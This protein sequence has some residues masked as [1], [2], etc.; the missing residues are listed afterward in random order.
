MITAGLFRR[1]IDFSPK[2]FSAVRPQKTI[3]MT[4]TR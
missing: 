4:I 2:K 3:S 1:R